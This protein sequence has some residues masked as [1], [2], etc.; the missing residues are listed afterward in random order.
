[1]AIINQLMARYYFSGAD[2]IGKLVTL[3]GDNQPYEIVG[4]VADAKYY[5]MRESAWRTIYFNT[6][7]ERQVASQFVLRTSIDPAAVSGDVRSAIGAFLKTVP[8]LRVTTLA[9]QVEA[10]IVPER[11]IATLSGWFGALGLILTAAGFYGLL[12]Y[13]VA[14]RVN[15]IGVRMA[16]GATRNDVNRM[17]LGDAL[18]MVCAGLAIGTPLAFWSRSVATKL[19]E[20]LP[21]GSVSP[22][23][24]GAVSMI[25]VALLAAYVPARR[26][27]RVDRW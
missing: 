16:L 19:I 22:I 2:A 10:S 24:F 20:D 6:F 23:V 25:A 12:A 14:R 3:D 21:L 15:E 27:A 7:Q 1:V 9:D 17:V 8:V 18:V 5:D 13:T 11:L 4:V 26:A